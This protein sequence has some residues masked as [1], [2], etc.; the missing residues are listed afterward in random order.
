MNGGKIRRYQLMSM[1]RNKMLYLWT[2][3]LMIYW[4]VWN[5]QA[6]ILEK[7]LIHFPGKVNAQVTAVGLTDAEGR[8]I[9]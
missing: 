2:K 9:Q 4:L 6:L 3:I 5:F 1:M 8:G 7:A